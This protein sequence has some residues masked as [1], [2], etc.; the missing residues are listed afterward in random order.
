MS[1]TQAYNMGAGEGEAIWFFGTLGTLKAS[2]EHTGGAFTLIEQEGRN[3]V[4]TPLHVQMDDPESFY[5]LEGELTFFVDGGEP[6]PAPAGSF[7]HVPAGVPHAFQV[8]SD[9]AR[10]L[11][12]TTPRHEAFLR[13]AGEPAQA[14]ELPPEGPPDMQKIMG[15]VDEYN[16][17]ILG[18]PPGRPQS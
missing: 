7:V 18:P 8:E 3:S 16:I 12:L 4:A 1:E 6:I 11:D 2:G 17:S 5:V 13:A 14:R 9:T 10:W 15:L